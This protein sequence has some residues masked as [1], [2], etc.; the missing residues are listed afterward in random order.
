MNIAYDV[1]EARGFFKLNLVS[2]GFTL[3][4]IVFL[5]L[6]LSGVVVLPIALNYIGLGGV[7][8][9]LLSWGRWPALL[10]VVIAALAA[11][12]RFG[13]SP[14]GVRWRWVSPGSLVASL[15]WIAAS[16]AFSYYAAN[17]ASYNETYGSLGA[18]IGFMT[19]IWISMIVILSGAELNG[20]FEAIE[21]RNTSKEGSGA[22][23]SSTS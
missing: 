16:A 15:L 22:P 7:S 21:R 3:S 8:A 4:A 18:I 2:L 12:Y 1:K 5:I 11:L 13:T 9:K 6:A 10:V 23:K 20:Q 14:R 17:F 19:W